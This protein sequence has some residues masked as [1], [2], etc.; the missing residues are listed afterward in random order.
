MPSFLISSNNLVPKARYLSYCWVCNPEEAS[1]YSNCVL[2]YRN[3][4]LSL[5]SNVSFASDTFYWLLLHLATDCLFRVRVSVHLEIIPNIYHHCKL[6]SYVIYRK[7]YQVLKTTFLLVP[8]ISSSVGLASSRFSKD[9][10]NPSI[11]CLELVRLICQFDK[12]TAKH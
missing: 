2:G 8:S 4:R 11:D 1:I 5:F 6:N 3:W 10:L 9:L 12:N 7:L